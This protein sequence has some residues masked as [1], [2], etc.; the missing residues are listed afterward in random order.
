MDKFTIII[1]LILIVFVVGGIMLYTDKNSFK[2][3]LES[4]V[5][6]SLN[7]HWNNSSKDTEFFGF[8]GIENMTAYNFE[9]VGYKSLKTNKVDLINSD[10]TITEYSIHN[11]PHKIMFPSPQDMLSQEKFVC[12]MYG[13]NKVRCWDNE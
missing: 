8:L 10:V 4:S 6:E 9:L 2:V 5:S 3:K 12:I 1:S 7:N 11:H 13:I